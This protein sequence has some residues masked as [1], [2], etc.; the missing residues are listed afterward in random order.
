[1]DDRRFDA[2]SR[3]IGEMG[4]P[5]LPR[6]GLLGLLGAGALGGAGLAL[7]WAPAADAQGGQVTGEANGCKKEGKNC[8]RNSD[9]CKGKCK[10]GACSSN[11]GNCKKE[12]KRCDRNKDCCKGK[13]V[14]STCSSS[15]KC[16][17]SQ[18]FDKQW[19]SNGSSDGKFKN[20]AGIA[21]GSN[22]EVY[23]ADNGNNRI[24]VFSTGGT[25]KRKWGSNGTG[26]TQF[27]DVQGIAV[28]SGNSGDRA[29]VSDPGQPVR[30]F[31]K[32]TTSGSFISDIT[33]ANMN[34]PFTVTAD[35]NRNLWVVDTSGRVFLFDKAGDPI[36]N[37]KPTGSGDITGAK[38]IAVWIDKSKDE[39]FVFIARTGSSTVVKFEYV[40]N[41]SNGLQFV[42]RVGS[43]GTGSSNFN[44]PADLAVDTCGNLWVAD[45]VND[46]IQKLDKDLKFKSSFTASFNRPTGIDLDPD[47]KFLYVVDS[48]NDR[49]IK[50]KLK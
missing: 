15:G 35:T 8:S 14:D 21:V 2:L 31:R 11:S 17:T 28:T 9:C 38:G 40:N 45:T 13:C 46:R 20:P 43:Q 24:Q 29:F 22:S 49:I 50:F 19:G 26:Q 27:T 6:R 34:D 44:K 47:G 5:R 7:T 3:R 30:R 41:N 23:V 25:F 36:A 39:T 33:P 42:K 16:L 12:G 4:M 18:D 10:N 32:F 48:F 37:W 1:M